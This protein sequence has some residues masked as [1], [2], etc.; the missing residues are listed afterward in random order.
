MCR[1]IHLVTFVADRL[2]I[3]NGDVI[4]YVIDGQ[5]RRIGERVNARWVHKWLYAGQLT[6]VAELDSTDNIV[7][8][9]SGSYMNKRDTIYQIITDHLGS[10]R[11]IVN[12]ATGVVVQ[13]ID[14]DEFGN[15]TYD[16]NPGFFRRDPFGTAIWI[17]WWTLR[18]RDEAGTVWCEGL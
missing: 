13:R 14:Y 16:S 12:V 3:P 18:C 2:V 15:V 4:Q 17:C 9:F 1:W 5:N 6:P 10:P 7:A 8:R 11:L